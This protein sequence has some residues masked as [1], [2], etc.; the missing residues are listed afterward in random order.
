MQATN[1]TNSPVKDVWYL[2]QDLTQERWAGM[3]RDTRKPIKCEALFFFL[4]QD[5]H[6]SSTRRVNFQ[7]IQIMNIYTKSYLPDSGIL[8]THF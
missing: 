4:T 3:S 8:S 5:L 1:E 2:A 6:V 7:A